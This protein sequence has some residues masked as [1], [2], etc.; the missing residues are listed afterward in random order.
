MYIHEE[1]KF[2]IITMAIILLLVAIVTIYLPLK[3]LYQLFIL[4]PVF[5]LFFLIIWFFRIPLR[6]SLIDENIIVS[7]A[8]GKVVV[9]EKIMETE[10]FKDER[11]QVSIFMSPLNV[12]QNIYPV[13]G[14]IVYTKYHKGKY[15]VA[16]HP[17]SSTLNERSSVVIKNRNGE[18]IMVK[19]IAGVAARRICAYSQKG[20]HVNQ[21]DELGFIK[22]GSRVDI[23]LPL[24]AK[25]LCKLNQKSKNKITRI[26]EFI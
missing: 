6:E 1:G 24:S 10:Y 12:H 5:V 16:W 20:N 15:M 2:A 26:A 13:S 11:I 4:F 21:C 7:P 17:K 8:D 14:T 25:I 23:I 9:I 22:F 19:Q 3:P 18:E